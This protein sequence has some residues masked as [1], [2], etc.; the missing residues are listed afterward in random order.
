MLFA[1]GIG[2]YIVLT[3]ESNLCFAVLEW[4]SKFKLRLYDHIT[5]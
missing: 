2:D 4:V 3:G 1:F 5:Q